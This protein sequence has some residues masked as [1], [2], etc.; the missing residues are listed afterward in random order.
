[1]SIIR[2]G[3]LIGLIMLII[4]GCADRAIMESNKTS[5]QSMQSDLSNNMLYCLPKGMINL[6]ITPKTGGAEVVV[7]TV[8]LPDK[9]HYYTLLHK[10]NRF[11]DDN[12]HITTSNEGFLKLIDITTESKLPAITLSVLD[13]GKE[14]FKLTALKGLDITNQLDIL[15][16]PD[17]IIKTKKQRDDLWDAINKF[18]EVDAGQIDI[19]PEEKKKL[20]AQIKDR[21]SS[22]EKYLEKYQI[23]FISL[24]KLFDNN[25]QNGS[26]DV[27]DINGIF[28][29]PVLPYLFELRFKE[30]S[31]VSKTIYLSNEAPIIS[32][33]ITRPAFVKKVVKLTFDN[34]GL[35]NDITINKPSEIEGF[36]GIP[37][38]I[39]KAVTGLPGE[40]LKFKVENTGQEVNYLQNQINLIQK[41]QE[42]MKL[43]GGQK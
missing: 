41:E 40:L 42:L 37:K 13:I 30:G 29:R 22:F 27:N 7:A 12:I 2:N 14:L 34:N 4:F 23:E 25:L 10:Y 19:N 24:M 8:Y 39:L 38:S 36:L 20:F 1:M 17:K 35:L 26:Y 33:E 3:I 11:Y 32:F 31:M 28:Y 16:E 21:Q 5:M 43:Q 18:K 15:I 9:D 6:K